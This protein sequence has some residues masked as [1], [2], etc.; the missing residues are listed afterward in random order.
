M[1]RTILRLY[2][3]L[4]WKLHFICITF[5]IFRTYL[6]ESIRK[7]FTWNVDEQNEWYKTLKCINFF[8]SYRHHIH[9]FKKKEPHRWSPHKFLITHITQILNPIEINHN[10]TNNNESCSTSNNNNAIKPECILRTHTEKIINKSQ[11]FLFMDAT[12][13]SFSRTLSLIPSSFLSF[14]FCCCIN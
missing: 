9:I 8:Y 7:W 4:R 6:I 1:H 10:N 14:V 13:G 2:S 3:V 12:Y 5:F 11:F